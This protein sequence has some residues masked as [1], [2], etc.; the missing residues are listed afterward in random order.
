MLGFTDLLVSFSSTTIEEALQN[1]VP[2]LM[3]G[4]EG[5]YQHIAAPSVAPNRA[6][7]PGAVYS[8]R[9]AEHLSDAISKILD[10]NGKAPLSE[11][12]FRPYVYRPDD[13]PPFSKLVRDLVEK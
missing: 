13:Y 9:K 7:E 2:V 12:L 6:V 1:R 4:G 11:E 5:R 10:R 3:Y 8:V